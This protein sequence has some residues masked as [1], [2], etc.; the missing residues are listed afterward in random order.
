MEPPALPGW[1]TLGWKLVNALSNIEYLKIHLGGVWDFFVTPLGNVLLIL[2]GLGWL[3]LVVFWPRKSAEPQD[4]G[5][6]GKHTEQPKLLIHSALYGAGD[7]SDIQLA[8]KLNRLAR[9]GMVV[10]VNRSIAPFD[11]APGKPKS[12]KVAYTFD[13]VQQEPASVPEDYWL[14]LPQDPQLRTL[15]TQLQQAEAIIA[16]LNKPPDDVH[17]ELLCFQRGTRPTDKYSDG[18]YFLK[19][20]ISCD[21]DTGLKDAVV[22]LT[23]GNRFFEAH[24]IDDLSEWILKTRFATKDYPHEN[25]KEESMTEASLWRDLQQHGLRSGLVKNGWIAVNIGELPIITTVSEV[26]ISITK[27]KQRQPSKFTFSVLP[28]CEDAHI[29]DRAFK[30]L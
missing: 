25:T 2:C 26:Q 30:E 28:E 20:K 24:P 4:S 27:S 21:E 5:D 1:I 19:L 11:P 14:V 22:R 17:V 7:A 3:A 9:V 10:P 13:G 15:R 12:L 23:I 8:D 6:A 29:F 18:T 16:T